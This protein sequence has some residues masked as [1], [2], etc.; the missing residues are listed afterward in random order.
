MHAVLHPWPLKGNG[1][2]RNHA[3]C[4]STINDACCWVQCGGGHLQLPVSVQVI[5]PR[6]ARIVQRQAEL[7]P[8]RCH[9]HGPLVHRGGGGVSRGVRQP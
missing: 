2:H 3:L 5:L 6:G 4:V 9:G 8:Q 7:L 1:S